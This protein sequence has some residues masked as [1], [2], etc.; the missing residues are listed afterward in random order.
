MAEILGTGI[1][2]AMKNSR[3]SSQSTSLAFAQWDV[4]LTGDDLDTAN[5]ES[6]GLNEG[7]LGFE[8]ADWNCGGDWDA[9]TNPYDDPP[10]FY[11]R[12]DLNDLLFYENVTDAV[13][14]DFPYARVRSSN[15]G[16]DIKGKVTFKASGKSQG[17]FNVPTGSV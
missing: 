11:P 14:W 9:G 2:R 15:N 13:L 8:G 7:I 4:T 17:P 12:D 10:G 5:F 3:V 6:E 16:G 1:Q